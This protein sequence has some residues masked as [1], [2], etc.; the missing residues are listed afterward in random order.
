MQRGRPA[1]K[2]EL[3]PEERATLENW[4]A[5][6]TQAP[7]LALRARIVLCCADGVTNMEVARR[8]DVTRETAGKWRRRYLQSGA[9]GLLDEPRPGA[10]STIRD[11]EIQR[12]R[13]LAEA[14]PPAGEAWTTRS[15][16]R[17]AN[18]SQT[19][20]SR[21]WKLFTLEPHTSLPRFFPKQG[22]CLER[23]RCIAGLYVDPP[24][25]A[26]ALCYDPAG[27]PAPCA[28]EPDHANGSQNGQE[29]VYAHLD[30]HARKVTG[31]VV[32]DGREEE[33]LAFLKGVERALPQGCVAHLVLGSFSIQ[34]LSRVHSWLAE[35]EHFQV[36]FIP[37]SGAWLKLV[38]RWA[39]ALEKRNGMRERSDVVV[40]PGFH[41]LDRAVQK[42]LQR[43]DGI[44]RQFEWLQRPE[45]QHRPASLPQLQST[46]G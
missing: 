36:H 4:S 5:D 33:F 44:G 24:L 30:A 17:S 32:R 9:Q 46:A 34:K 2:V 22:L 6:P 12:V 29:S 19:A 14:A 20:I 37:T 31:H 38:E 25:R 27:E 18:L 45:P 23:V 7:E 3:T 8:L 43:G 28:L 26:L 35:R 15:M 39:H 10:P 13:A 40:E 42:F 16:A 41:S 21:I 11:D 1:P